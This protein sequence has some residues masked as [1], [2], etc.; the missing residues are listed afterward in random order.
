MS[1]LPHWWPERARETYADLH[2][3]RLVGASA[4]ADRITA[5]L[6]EIADAVEARE[7]DLPAHLAEAGSRFSGLKPDTALYVNVS[8]ILVGAA[9][10]GSASAVRERAAALTADRRQAQQEVVARTV[11]LLG[12]ARSVLVHDYSSMVMRVLEQLTRPSSRRVVVTAGEPLGKGLAVARRAAEIGYAVTLAPDM[13]VGRVIDQVDAYLTGVETFYQDGSLANT[14]GTR[15]LALLAR[16]SGTPVIAPTETL[17]LDEDAETATAAALTAPLL[18]PWPGDGVEIP[19]EWSVVRFV[20]DAVPAMCITSFVTEEGACG[21]DDVGRVAQHALARYL[22]GA[23][24]DSQW[25]S[26]G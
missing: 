18:H 21:A 14:V 8:R 15:M 7:D 23:R 20:L 19:A 17:K 4:C 26:Q 24:G 16:D 9:R 5:A 6:V 13:S 10:T 11:A 3:Y 22:P 25:S 2:S 12:E 1:E